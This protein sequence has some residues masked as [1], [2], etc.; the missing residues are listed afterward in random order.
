MLLAGKGTLR[1]FTLWQGGAAL[2]SR[3]LL[4][5]TL[6]TQSLHQVTLEKALYVFRCL[7]KRGARGGL[8]PPLYCLHFITL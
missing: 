4:P 3:A 7:R 2:A 5:C 6:F 1:P 8:V